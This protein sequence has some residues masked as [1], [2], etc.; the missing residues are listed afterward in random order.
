[1]LLTLTVNSLRALA[2]PG[3]K[4]R[5]VGTLFDLPQY[6]REHLGLHGLNLSTALLAGSTRATL[7]RLRERADQARCACLLVL[8]GVAQPLG[9]PD[10]RVAAGG[11]E[12]LRKVVQAAHLLGCSAA[13]IRLN[14]PDTPEVFRRTI[15]RLRR[16]VEHAARLELNVLIWPTEGLTLT[17]ERVTEMIKKAGGFRVGTFPDFETA[18]K[19]PDSGEYLRRLTPYAGGISATTLTFVESRQGV[20]RHE[21]YD[22]AP[23]VQAVCAVGYDGM[24]AVDYRGAGEATVG[25][26]RSRDMLERLLHEFARPGLR[27]A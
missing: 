19:W 3:Q 27:Q 13:V 10:E 26:I 14:G 23:L 2:K 4:T 12:R 15:D 20:V 17:P 5:P 24:L 7:D 8:E 21:P 22:L 11:V 1:M 16:V 6:V 25:I 18:A 9:D